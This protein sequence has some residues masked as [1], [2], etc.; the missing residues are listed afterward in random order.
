MADL[1]AVISL[2]KLAS[3]AEA[4]R[5]SRSE[6]LVLIAAGMA[7]IGLLAVPPCWNGGMDMLAWLARCVAGETL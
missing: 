7:S 2:A 3:P 5:P 4:H 1:R 6:V